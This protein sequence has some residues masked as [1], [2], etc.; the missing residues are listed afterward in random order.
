MTNVKSHFPILSM[1]LFYELKTRNMNHCTPNI[2]LRLHFFPYGNK[3]ITHMSLEGAIS[4]GSR[5]NFF[6]PYQ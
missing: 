1:D 6:K 3:D 2:D 5:L 4:L